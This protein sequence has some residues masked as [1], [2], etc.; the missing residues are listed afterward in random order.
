MSRKEDDKQLT[1]AYQTL[2]NSEHGKLVLKDLQAKFGWLKPSAQPGQNPTDAFLADGMKMP[3]Y[4]INRR[5]TMSV[6]NEEKKQTKAKSG[7]K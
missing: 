1:I 6:D 5:L 4:E 3:L 2:F 7:I